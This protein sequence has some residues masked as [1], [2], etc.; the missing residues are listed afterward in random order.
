MLRESVKRQFDILFITGKEIPLNSQ[1]DK[2]FEGR[3]KPVLEIR[4]F[5]SR[6]PP[7][8]P[9]KENLSI[10][11][12]YSLQKRRTE[13]TV[14]RRWDVHSTPSPLVRVQESEYSPRT[15]VLPSGPGESVRTDLISSTS[16]LDPSR[17]SNRLLEGRTDF[18]IEI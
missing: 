4:C 18:D 11:T 12:R 7:L 9:G 6:L 5:L 16:C 8:S 14:T 15:H 2:N 17:H 13:R 10:G 3:G 1:K